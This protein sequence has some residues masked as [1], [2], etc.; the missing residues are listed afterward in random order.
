MPE[1]NRITDPLDELINR[2]RAAMGEETTTTEPSGFSIDLNEKVDEISSPAK[3]KKEFVV[4]YGDDDLKAEIEEEDRAYEESR[5]KAYEE[6]AA[7]VAELKSRTN[8]LPPQPHNKE[9]EARDIQFQADKL[10]IVTTMVNR[11]VAKYHIIEGGIPD[12]RSSDGRILERRAVMGELMD[13]YHADGDVIT[14]EFENMILSNW[15]LP[16][17][18]TAKD[19][20]DAY[21]RIV[22]S[23][24]LKEDYTNS[25]QSSTVETPD[26]EPENTTTVE[27]GTKEPNK[28]APTINITVEKNTPVTINV[29]E[30]FAAE[31]VNTKELNVYVKEVSDIELRAS[32]IIENSEQEGIISA[33]DSGLHDVP[34]TLP[35]SAYRCVLRPINWF[36]FIKLAAPVSDNPSDVELRKWSVIYDHIKNVSI[37][38]FKDFEDF[39]KK[40]KY[41]DREL[42]MWA[43]LVATADDEEPIS[44]TCGNPKCKN[45]IKCKYNPRLLVHLDEKLIPAHYQKTH[46]VV[47]GEEAVDHWN[48]VNGKRKRYQLP[49]T[50][51]IVEINEPSAYEFI[52]IR[53]PLIQN[54]YKKYDPDGKMQDLKSEDPRMAE[55][56]YLS[57][58]AL[59]ISAMTIVKG[60]KE[61]RYTKWEDIERI[62]TTSLDS[63]DSSIL[64]KLIQQVRMT[65][66]P[67]TFYIENVK[68]P[69]CGRNEPKVPITDIGQ[70]LLFQISQRLNSI[71]INLKELD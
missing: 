56:D 2:H 66:S 9:E 28:E 57:A 35:L 23:N 48:H 15:M 22:S 60:N 71:E 61:Y 24:E 34:I 52:T 40:T 45:S 70:T 16:S 51:I 30:S 12:E 38:D 62:I 13:M 69:V 4:N 27:T 44:F 6:N 63:V 46:D 17:G 10:A 18:I 25:S 58:N 65:T 3:D 42:L 32:T 49:S 59:F 67:V 5:R 11:V 54:L 21:G 64:L 19:S 68:C 47:R 31:T 53:L 7:K 8:A 50:G 36:D 39:L 26:D 43:L 37:G 55:F 41:Q 20:I 29:D 33:Y 1:N 14:P